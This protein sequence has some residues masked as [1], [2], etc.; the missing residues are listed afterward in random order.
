[1]G[2]KHSLNLALATHL[3]RAEHELERPALPDF[4]EELVIELAHE[5]LHRAERRIAIT[6]TGRRP[7]RLHMGVVKHG[8]C[9]RMSVS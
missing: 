6:K 1:M 2:Y 5:M 7:R 8:P 9:R 4:R 3:R